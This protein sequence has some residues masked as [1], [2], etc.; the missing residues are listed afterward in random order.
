M[1]DDRRLHQRL[2]MQ[3]QAYGRLYPSI[4]PR[5]KAALEAGDPHLQA[6]AEA[7]SE[8]L[9]QTDELRERRLREAWRLSP[10]EINV[11]LHLVDGGTVATCAEAMGVAES[12]VRTHLKSVFAKTGCSRQAQL[13][14]LVQNNV[15]MS[16]SDISKSD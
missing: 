11:T 8:R 1:R 2:M 10:K 3:A 7:V 12:T 13:P 16:D 5:L 14:S 4:I 6:L 9:A 15:G